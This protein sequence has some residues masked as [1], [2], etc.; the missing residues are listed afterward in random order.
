MKKLLFFCILLCQI[1]CVKAQTGLFF[2]SDRLTSTVITSICQDKTNY[3]WVGTEYGLNRF[4][5]YHFTHYL[6]QEGDSTSLLFNTVTTLFCDNQGRLWVGTTKGLQRYDE[7][8]N[9]F[10]TYTFPE[11]H[12]PHVSQLYQLR[13]GELLV[14]TSGYGICQVLPNSTKLVERTDY[15]VDEHDNYFNNLYEDATGTLWKSG[16]GRFCCMPKGRP[17]QQFDTSK[18]IPTS[19]FG[20]QGNIVALSRDDFQMFTPPTANQHQTPVNPFDISVLGSDAGFRTALIDQQGNIYVGTLG[21]G[22]FWIPAGTNKLIRHPV[23]M[24]GLDLKSVKIWALAEDRQ[25]NI[26]V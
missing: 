1:V 24:M 16:A 18:G 20:Y 22:L 15:K 17:A 5:G 21:S 11:R 25:G 4:D 26:W 19:I 23:R 6:H 10:T 12:K 3:I 9:S 8:T 14:G 7:A 13:S 2:G